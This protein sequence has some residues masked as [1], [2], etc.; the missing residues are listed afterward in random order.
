[1]SCETSL[2]TDRPASDAQKSAETAHPAL[3][4]ARQAVAR[5]FPSSET[6][7]KVS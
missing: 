3:K 7:D 4:E 6:L 2:R 1:M 5:F